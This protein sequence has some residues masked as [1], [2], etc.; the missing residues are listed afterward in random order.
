MARSTMW[1]IAAAA[2]ADQRA[3][4]PR[5]APGRHRGLR[6][7][8]DHRAVTRVRAADRGPHRGPDKRTAAGG[9]NAV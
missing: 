1:N 4:Q 5:R 3:G 7:G 6:G 8:L 9:G 2:P